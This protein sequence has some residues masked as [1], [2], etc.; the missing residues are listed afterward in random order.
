VNTEPR[1]GF[2]RLARALHLITIVV[3]RAGEIR[4]AFESKP[5]RM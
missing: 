5:Q 1:R 4:A 2:S 3:T